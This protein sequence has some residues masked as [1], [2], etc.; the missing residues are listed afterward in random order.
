MNAPEKWEK[1]GMELKDLLLTRKK[2]IVPFIIGIVLLCGIGYLIMQKQMPHTV[3]VLAGSEIS[4]GNK[5]GEAAKNGS[6]YSAGSSFARGKYASPRTSS[7]LNGNTNNMPGSQNN[8]AGIDKNATG[9]PDSTQPDIWIHVTGAVK[10]PG[11]VCIPAGSRIKDAIAF[12][13]GV[14]ENADLDGVNLVYELKDGQKI[15]V[16][17]KRAVKEAV[18]KASASSGVVEGGTGVVGETGA[19]AAG[20]NVTVKININTAAAAELDR[21]P[22]IGP[23]MAEKIIK[24][25]KENGKFEKIEEIMNVP[26]IGK[27]K[28]DRMK[29]LIAVE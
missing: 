26:G 28:F 12:A 6:S 10:Q 24:F 25:R 17:F 23:S 27:A 22:G 20:S 9:M 7:T 11:A 1:F 13:G 8:N 19:T 15:Y 3:D 2:I 16:P 14:A 21:L 29:D 4:A 18:E 5:A